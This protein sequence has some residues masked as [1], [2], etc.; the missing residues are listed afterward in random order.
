V[1]VPAGL[2]AGGLVAAVAALMT[3]EYEIDLWL[4]IGAGA[5]TGLAVG[6]VTAAVG[7]S[8]HR[9]VAGAAGV[10][11]AAGLVWAGRID[12][13]H[14]LEPVKAGAWAGAVAAGL[15]AVWRVRTG[16]R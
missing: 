14:G 7:R 15:V 8:T 11:A 2:V 6:E 9:L 13:S 5:L 10:T 4:G 12:A 1:R 3:G 16:R